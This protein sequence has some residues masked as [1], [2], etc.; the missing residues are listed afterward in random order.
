MHVPFGVVTGREVDFILSR[1]APRAEV[2]FGMHKTSARLPRAPPA[3]RRMFRAEER[4]RR[5]DEAFTRMVHLVLMCVLMCR[6]HVLVQVHVQVP[7][8]YTDKLR[9]LQ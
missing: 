3:T 7:R 6:V 9:P 2:H 1:Y 4:L 5:G 8:R